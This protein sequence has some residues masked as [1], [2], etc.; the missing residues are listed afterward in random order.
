MNGV[1]MIG[2]LGGT[3]DPVH[4]GH[5]RAASEAR[6]RLELSELRLVPA[7]NP[8]HRSVTH[9]SAQHRLAML[10]LALEGHP[11]LLADDRELRR[12]GYSYMVDTLEEIRREE[13]SKALLLMIGQDAANVL[14]TWHDWQQLFRL[15]HIVIMRRPDSRDVYSGQL[16]R[17]IQSRLVH[18]A[19]YLQTAPAGKV[20][21]LEVTQLAIS[22]TDI[23]RQIAQG[24]S[25]RFL[26][27]DPVI[28]YIRQQGLYR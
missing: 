14:D 9:A 6:E 12:G 8:P 2:I 25:P 15:T 28:G 11:D 24:L 23:R 4:F 26:L 1:P 10:K 21:T 19:R 22:S 17:E 3:F 5:L 7:G 20:L 27:P 16:L 13:G 18:E